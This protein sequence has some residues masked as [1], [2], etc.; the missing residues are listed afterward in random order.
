MT[1]WDASAL[2]KPFFA[3]A[4]LSGVNLITLYLLHF[5]KSSIAEVKNNNPESWKNHDVKR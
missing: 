1:D 5:A 3:E 2:M 4:G